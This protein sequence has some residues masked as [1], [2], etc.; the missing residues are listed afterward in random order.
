[1]KDK[2]DI[3]EMWTDPRIHSVEQN[4]KQVLVGSL[5]QTLAFKVLCQTPEATETL[6]SSHVTKGNQNKTQ[7]VLNNNYFDQY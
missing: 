5:R 3:S 7:V 1:M 4:S 2:D 6:T